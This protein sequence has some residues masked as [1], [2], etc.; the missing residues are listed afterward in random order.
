MCDSSPMQ[1][2]AGVS[3]L[4]IIYWLT[5]L[6]LWAGYT[7]SAAGC[8][9]EIAAQSLIWKDTIAK[10][11]KTDARRSQNKTI[12]DVAID[13]GLWR[14]FQI[15]N[16]RQIRILRKSGPSKPVNF[17]LSEKGNCRTLENCVRSKF[18]NCG[19][20]EDVCCHQRGLL[21]DFC[22]LPLMLHFVWLFASKLY[23]CTITYWLAHLLKTSISPLPSFSPSSPPPPPLSFSPPP[24]PPHFSLPVSPSPSADQ[25][26]LVWL[27]MALLKIKA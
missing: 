8:W 19:H 20:F 27:Q 21:V 3:E 18:S 25:T 2:R 22:T 9:Y 10:D 14:I 11:K 6:I 26:H 24:N 13:D 15:N 16:A 23:G 4:E 17:G 7:Y 1:P 5:G 12:S